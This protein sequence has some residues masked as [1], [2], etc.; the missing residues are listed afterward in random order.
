MPQMLHGRHGDLS[1][2]QDR[3]PPVGLDV[4]DVAGDLHGAV[5]LFADKDDAEVG[6]G[7]QQAHAARP[8]AEEPQALDR[9]GLSNRCLTRHDRPLIPGRAG[10]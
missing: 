3:S 4:G 2:G 1:V 5:I 10:A 8:A 6:L 7:R 9:C